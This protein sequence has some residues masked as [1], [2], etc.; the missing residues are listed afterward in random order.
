MVDYIIVGG[1]SA[2]CVL[3]NRL[4]ADPDTEVLLLEAGEPNL[5]LDRILDPARLRELVG[6]ELDWGFETTPQPELNGRRIQQPRGKTLGG[7]SAINGMAWVR[8]H[9]FDYN[10]WAEAVD[11]EGWTFESILPLYERM[12][13]LNAEGDEAYHGSDG[14]LS[15]GRHSGP[16]GF[17]ERLVEAGVEAGLERNPDFNGEQQAGVGYYHY[18]VKNGTRHSAA[19]AYLKP[20]LDRENLHVETGAHVTEIFLEGDRGGVRP[21]RHPPGGLRRRGRGSVARGRGHSVPAAAD[22]LGHRPCR[23]PRVT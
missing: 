7:S 11:D 12:E 13:Q 2:G 16:T 18:S 4:T 10:S 21:G 5:D 1:G 6:T 23:P 17:S 3:A 8:G 20:V 15:V 22:A 14:P 19:E 9:P